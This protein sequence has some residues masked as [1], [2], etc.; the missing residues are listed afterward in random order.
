LEGLSPRQM[1]LISTVHYAYRALKDYHETQPTKEEVVSSASKLKGRKF[2]KKSLEKVYDILK[3]YG[4]LKW[5]NG[6]A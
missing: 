5:G 6:L 4:L 3:E 2:R 1:E